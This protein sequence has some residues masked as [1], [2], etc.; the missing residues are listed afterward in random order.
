[1]G[2]HDVV[3]TNKNF[4]DLNPVVFG[5]EDCLPS[6]SYGPGIREYYLVHYVSGGKGTFIVN[7]K[8][9]SVCK[10]QIFVAPPYT[11]IQY[12]ADKHDPWSYIWIGFCGKLAKKFD[13]LPPVADI[14]TNIFSE[15][16]EC[17]SYKS[18]REE[19]LAGKLYSLYAQLFEDADFSNDYVKQTSD[20]I[21]AN[22]MND[23]SIADI[24]ALI[25]VERTYLS[26]IFKE[27]MGKSIQEYRINVRLEQARKLLEKG[28]NVSQASFMCGYK[29]SFNFSKMFKK[30]YGISPQKVKSKI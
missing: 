30:R 6:H 14:K 5:F 7:N 12:Y 24:A 18:C 8:R 10:N 9:Y 3:I 20:Y 22:Y 29:D 13:T 4:P 15:M 23:I 21:S 28:Y 25:G 19:F 16:I 17:E 27:K 26:K 1:M 2:Y 11:Q